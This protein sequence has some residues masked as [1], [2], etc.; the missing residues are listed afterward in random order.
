M[1]DSERTA[2]AKI[3]FDRSKILESLVTT[4]TP[5]IVD[6]GANM[7]QSIESFFSSFPDA[8]I[9][10]FEP[11]EENITRLHDLKAGYGDRLHVIPKALAETTGPRDFFFSRNHKRINR[12]VLRSF[13]LPLDELRFKR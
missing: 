6:V 8:T 12:M 7:G 9:H 4:G 2:L 3:K 13:W 5:L 11:A 1:K 10:A